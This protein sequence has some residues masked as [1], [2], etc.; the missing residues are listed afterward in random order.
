MFFSTQIIIQNDCLIYL[1]NFLMHF[2]PFKPYFQKYCQTG[3]VITVIAPVN[4]IHFKKL[5]LAFDY[6][7]LFFLHGGVADRKKNIQSKLGLRPES[8]GTLALSLLK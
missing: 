7:T 1:L 8:L 4:K 5:T 2:S 6:I 3:F